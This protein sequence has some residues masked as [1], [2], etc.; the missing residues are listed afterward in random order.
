MSMR[1]VRS[2]VL[3]TFRRISRISTRSCAELG[4]RLLQHIE[5]AMSGIV[6][7]AH[8]AAGAKDVFDHRDIADDML[9]FWGGIENSSVEPTLKALVYLGKYLERIDLYTRFGFAE[10]VLPATVRKLADHMEEL[11]ELPVPQCFADGLAWLAA[12]LPGR[13]YDA[14]AAHLRGMIEG[15]GDRVVAFDADAA[16]NLTSMDMD[17]ERP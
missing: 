7:A 8:H 15:L 1:S 17:A 6:D 14:T 13:G 4:S 10:E 9:A 2:H 3:W 12:Q 11:D 16:G 5:L